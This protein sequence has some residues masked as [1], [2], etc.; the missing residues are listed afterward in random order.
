MLAMEDCNLPCWETSMVFHF[1]FR[2]NGLAWF[3]QATMLPWMFSKDSSGNVGAF[4]TA[5]LILLY[6]LFN[7]SMVSMVSMDLSVGSMGWRSHARYGSMVSMVT[8]W[9]GWQ[10]RGSIWTHSQT[11]LSMVCQHC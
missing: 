9:E 6:C 4:G 11:G 3:Y 8:A 10:S 7:N 1:V 2:I 5:V